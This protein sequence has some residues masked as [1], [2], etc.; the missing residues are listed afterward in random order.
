[1]TPAEPSQDTPV[2]SHRIAS[3]GG[4]RAWTMLS[5]AAELA[6]MTGTDTATTTTANASGGI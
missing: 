4:F 1:M 3:G 5:S 6:R 2:T